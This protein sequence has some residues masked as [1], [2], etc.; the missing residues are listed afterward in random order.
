MIRSLNNDDVLLARGLT[1]EFDGRFDGFGAR[2]PEEEGVE[3]WVRH[4]R[5]Q[6]VDQPEIRFTEA[7]VYLMGGRGWISDRLVSEERAPAVPARE[8]E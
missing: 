8:Q 1:C 4:H 5:Q 2:V 3:T 6:L 7:D